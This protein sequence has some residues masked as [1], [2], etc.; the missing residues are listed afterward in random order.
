MAAAVQA[1]WKCILQQK[2]ALKN[3]ERLLSV[4]TSCNKLKQTFAAHKY[5]SDFIVVRFIWN[6]S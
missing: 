3:M 1:A 6:K 4:E 2:Y 5:K